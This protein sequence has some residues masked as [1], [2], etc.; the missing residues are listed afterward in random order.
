M[1]TRDPHAFTPMLEEG[2]R[3]APP[4][5]L[6]LGSDLVMNQ[7]EI[8]KFSQKDAEANTWKPLTECAWMCILDLTCC[9][10]AYPDFVKHLDKLAAAVQ[11]LLDAPPV[12]ITGATSG[13]LRK[14]L[15]A[16][17]TTIPMVKCGVC[18]NA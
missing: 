13:S 7:R 16:V 11:P 17:K 1:Y 12:D 2:L 3:G 14:R 9:S 18:I 4:R 5:S 6:T 10:Q 8:S 15:A